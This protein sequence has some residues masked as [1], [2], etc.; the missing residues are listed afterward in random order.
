IERGTLS[1]GHDSI[2]GS[3]GR[4]QDWTL[5]QV[6]N[7][8]SITTDGG[9]PQSRPV[10]QQNE[11]TSI[12]GLTTPGYDSDGNTTTDETNHALTYDA[13]NR[14]MTFGGT[15]ETFTYDALGRRI[16]SVAGSTTRHL[17]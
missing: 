13:W 4:T 12:T 8:T 9:T 17:Y 7:A 11:I 2:S 5:D 3:A 14:L 6:G 1:A 15:S 16:T 10:N